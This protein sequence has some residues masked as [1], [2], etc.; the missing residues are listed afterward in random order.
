MLPKVPGGFERHEDLLSE[1]FL[2]L[3]QNIRQFQEAIISRVGDPTDSSSLLELDNYQAYLESAIFQ[4]KQDLLVQNGSPTLDACL[5][6]A[7]IFTYMLHA[8]I[9]QASLVPSYWSNKLLDCLQRSKPYYT[10]ATDLFLW[11]VVIGGSL[12]ASEDPIK[13]EFAALVKDMYPH[14]EVMAEIGLIDDMEHKM[15]DFLWAP[16]KFGEQCKMYYQMYLIEG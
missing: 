12:L 8:D 11:L 2:V 10:E 5:M 15:Q 3:A 14:D 7:Y 4:Q 9:W 1:P 13:A 6:A 16:G